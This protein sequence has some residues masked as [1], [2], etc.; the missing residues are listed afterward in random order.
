[1]L[2]VLA[3]PYNDPRQLERAAGGMKMSGLY[4]RNT[5]AVKDGL[6]S[7]MASN[8]PAAA[9]PIIDWMQEIGACDADLSAGDLPAMEA[10]LE[11]FFETMPRGDVVAAAEARNMIIAPV[12]T[13]ADVRHHPHL[14]AR[15]FFVAADPAEPEIKQP[16]P[17]CKF[18]DRDL[19]LE[20]PAPRLCQHTDEVAAEVRPPRTVPATAPSDRRPPFEGLKV[21]DLGWVGVG[22]LSM[23]FL[24]DFGAT[25][26]KVESAL[27]PDLARVSGPHK[28]GTA[29]LDTSAPFHTANAGKL[30]LTLNLA[31]PE[32]RDVFRRLAK[33][34]DVIGQ[35]FTPKVMEKWGLGYEELAR[36]NPG[37][38]FAAT[39]L[40]GQTGPMANQP[41]YGTQAAGLSGLYYLTGW[42]DRLPAG[43]SGP[44]TDFVAPRF[45]SAAIAAALDERARTGKGTIVDVSQMESTIHYLTPALLDYEIN[46]HTM[47]ADGNRSPDM[48]PHG[49][50]RC[51]G[52]DR[53]VA[54]A[55]VDDSQ[56]KALCAVL[57][58][59][60]LAADESLSDLAGRK[61]REAELEAIIEAWTSPRS[62]EQA[63][64][65]LIA[66]DVAAHLVADRDD[67]YHDPQMRHRRHIVP[68]PHP[69]LGEVYAENPRYQ[70]SA[71][72]AQVTRPGPM[73][74]QHNDYVLS[75][76][77]GYSSAEIEALRAADALQ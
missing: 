22:P 2:Q 75:E 45:V 16:G 37:L 52:E 25:V 12:N 63:Q 28:N 77:L 70:L 76:I 20:R 56:W 68:L 15:C 34:A 72:P 9:Q 32:A 43:P 55:A 35:S 49:V 23:R 24:A 44:Y 21:V 53:W 36:I 67:L 30:G 47:A 64:E 8:V 60:D 4:R 59:P 38:I 48:A 61:Q 27:R 51:Q 40:G 54:V 58:R 29:G 10:A 3:G 13:V 11:A 33:W 73:R 31:T 19:A 5:Y 46:H 7:V 69:T 62:A 74:G 71:T 17:F 26:I 65:L 14:E 66:A 42:P 1:M 6:V 39:C 18:T 50:F 41:G 57:G